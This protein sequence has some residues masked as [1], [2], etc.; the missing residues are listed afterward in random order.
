MTALALAVLAGSFATAAPATKPA[1][2]ARAS[3]V[4]AISSIAESTYTVS[5]LYTGDRVRDPFLPPSMGAPVGGGR[6]A[7]DKGPLSVNIHTL[8][9]RGIMQDGRRQFAI[10]STAS[11]LTLMLR[12]GR[13]Y[14]DLNNRIPGISGSI[15][16]RQKRAVLITADKDVQI[17]DLGEKNDQDGAR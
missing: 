10:F 4:A 2:P 12:G 9:L 1:A 11:G 13:L 7:G 6:P 16:I 8:Q 15:R 5:T 3:T 14:D 17:F